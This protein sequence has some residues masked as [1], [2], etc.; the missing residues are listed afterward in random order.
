MEAVTE[1]ESTDA[2]EEVAPEDMNDE[3][4]TEM[5]SSGNVELISIENIEVVEDRSSEPDRG[6]EF[7]DTSDDGAV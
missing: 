7:V 5:L 1:E 3:Q 2:Q 4:I 6:D